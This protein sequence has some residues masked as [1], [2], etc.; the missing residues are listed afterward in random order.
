MSKIRA[1]SPMV[2]TPIIGIIRPSLI[3]TWTRLIGVPT[4]RPSCDYTQDSP[5]HLQ[6]TSDGGVTEQWKFAK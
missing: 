4:V 5:S 2:R 1:G 6:S 3:S